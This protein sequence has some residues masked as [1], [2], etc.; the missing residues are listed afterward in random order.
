M[1][2]IHDASQ[3]RSPYLHI[4][5]VMKRLASFGRHCSFVKVDRGQVRVSH[6]LVN[7]ARTEQQ[8]LVMFGSGPDVVIQELELEQ[9]VSPTTQ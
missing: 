3:D 9:N 6:C 1:A 4:I 5:Y 2:A 7:W 8:T